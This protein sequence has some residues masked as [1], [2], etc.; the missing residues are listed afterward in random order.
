M[1]KLTFKRN[2]SYSKVDGKLRGYRTDETKILTVPTSKV[3]Y[4]TQNMGIRWTLTECRELKNNDHGK[5]D[6]KERN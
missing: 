1:W 4:V 5:L 2:V 3:I 6:G